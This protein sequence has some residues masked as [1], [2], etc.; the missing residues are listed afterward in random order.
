MARYERDFRG[1]AEEPLSLDQL[2]DLLANAEGG[3]ERSR[4]E[5]IACY[6]SGSDGWRDAVKVLDGAFAGDKTG[7]KERKAD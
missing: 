4:E 1:V 3:H 5:A 6:L 2:L 7:L